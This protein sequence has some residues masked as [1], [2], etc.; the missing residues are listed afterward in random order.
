MMKSVALHN[1]GCK[2]NSYELD[3]IGQKLKEKGFSIVPFD[4][5][6]DIYMVNTCTVTNIADRKS[7]QMLHQAKKRNPEA[8]VVAIG[9]YVQTGS[10]QVL[11]DE[12]VDLVI[13]NNR[14]KDAVEILEEYLKT[15][16]DKTVGGRSLADIG[17]ETVYEEVQLVRTAEHTRAYIKIQDGCNQFCSY[18]IIPYARGRVRSRREEDILREVRGLAADGFREIVLTGIH[19]SSYGLDL[20]GIKN[21]EGGKPFPHERLL[22]L[23]RELDQVENLA[24]IRL[25]SLE[26]RI[27]TPAFAAGLKGIGKLCH[28]FH[29][30]L[31]SGCDETLVRMNRHYTAGE[32]LEKVKLLRET[33]AKPAITTDVIVG[34][35]GET[36]E[37]FERT[38][39]FL[40]KVNFYEMHVFPYSRREGT[41]AAARKDQVP[42]NVKK[43]RCRILLAL[44]GKQSAAFRESYIGK[45][46]SVLF[47]ETK[48]VCGVSCQVG[49]T[50][51][52]IRAA[53]KTRENLSGKTGIGR[54]T[55]PIREDSLS[56][57]KASDNIMW[58]E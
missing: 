58:L 39:D 19:I 5:K 31:Q 6:A 13:G 50:G 14:K 23:L 2:V 53:K 15:R 21:P 28:H 27:I 49:Y 33:F 24:R 40:E 44:A 47:E 11:G 36:D 17:R 48:E 45:E 29:L 20:D 1:L 16:G 8:V 7:R 37:E 42:E 34:F 57:G 10:E 54:L 35:P 32:Y 12:A 9:C 25:G 46:V 18:C 41:P 55:G 38:K 4:E 22:H 30:S 52:Y 43:E 26:P 51:E 3:V 56:G